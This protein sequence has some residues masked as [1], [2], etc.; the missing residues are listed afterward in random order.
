[1]I[2]LLS[3][4]GDTNFDYVIDWLRFYQHPYLR[5][6]SDDLLEDDFHLSLT[7]RRLRLRQQEVDLESIGAVWLRH[8]GNFHL[9]RYYKEAE[10][11]LRR[12]A[13][14]HLSRELTAT[15]RAL[16][17]LL[18]QKH[19]L[20]HP[21]RASVNKLDM[22]LRAQESGLAIPE[23]HI[24]NRKQD[25]LRLLQGGEYIT[26]S[27]YEPLFLQEERGLYSMYTK[28]VDA[29]AAEGYGEAFFPSLLQRKVEKAYDL[30]IFYLDG[31]CYSM[32]IFSQQAP[33]TELDSRNMDWTD[34]PHSVPYALPQ[35][36]EEG[37]RRFMTGI[38]LNCGSLDMVRSTD[39]R[40]YFLEVNPTGQFGMVSFPCN[41]PLYEKIALH[42]MHHDHHG[43][44]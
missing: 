11:R 8:F 13:L 33:R 7:P 1:M 15:L 35:E 37:I 43:R 21:S 41:Y 23:T 28:E 20:T 29:T 44:R 14:E 34:A 9:S 40:Y 4:S 32:A 17:V 12:E 22:L 5:I 2:L 30:R 36:C 25:L 16:I 38:G 6:N 27:T 3:Y 18:D 26:K 19:W 24:V 39:G 10:T 42:L 31:E